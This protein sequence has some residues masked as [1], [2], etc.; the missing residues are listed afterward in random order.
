MSRPPVRRYSLTPSRYSSISATDFLVPF[1]VRHDFPMCPAL[2]RTDRWAVII[3]MAGHVRR[4]RMHREIGVSTRLGPGGRPVVDIRKVRSDR[5]IL[6]RR[7]E[8][9]VW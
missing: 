8:S 3:T 5:V 9:I 7:T 6:Y 4:D 1:A 2:Q